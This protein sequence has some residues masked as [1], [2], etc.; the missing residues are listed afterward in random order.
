MKKYMFMLLIVSAGL[1]FGS[2]ESCSGSEEMN[3]LTETSITDIPHS[4]Y[5]QPLLE[6]WSNMIHSFGATLPEYDFQALCEASLNSSNVLNRDPQFM[7][8]CLD[9]LDRKVETKPE[10]AAIYYRTFVL[11][12]N[13]SGYSRSDIV[14]LFEHFLQHSDSPIAFIEMHVERYNLF[15]DTNERIPT[16]DRV[17]A[18][19]SAQKIMESGKS[20][21]KIESSKSVQSGTPYGAI[22]SR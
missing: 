4:T 1:C 19:H 5:N 3:Q 6:K 21:W 12:T 13:R 18:R 16:R 9:Y 2:E 8:Y 7:Q 22:G 11:G 17:I 15:S 10:N 20:V 14:K